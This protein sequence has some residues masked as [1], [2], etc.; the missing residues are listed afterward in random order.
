VRRLLPSAICHLVLLYALILPA[1]AA[2]QTANRPSVYVIVIDGLDGDRVD[3]GGAP[4][5]K[6]MIEGREGAAATY[7][8]E[9]RSTMI[10]E[11]NPNHTSMATGAYGGASGIPGNA[12]AIYGTP[13]SAGACATTGIDESSKPTQSSGE[14]PSCLQAETLF[15]ALDRQAGD[16]VTTAGIFGKPKLGRLF[17]GKRPDGRY[18]ADY[19]WAPCEEPGDD[20]PY[21]KTVP[22]N[23]ATRYAADDSVVMDE[24][25][26]AA[27]E[28]VTADGGTKK[29]DY[30]FVNLPQVDSAGHATGA[31]SVYD[32]AIELADAEIRRFVESQ[33]QLGLWGSRTVLLL[34][35]DHSMD[36]TPEK[37]S[38]DQRF[39]QAGIS[40][41]SYLIVQ[42]GSASLVYLSDRTDPARFDLLKKMRE[43]ALGSGNAAA[44]V[45]G[46]GPISQALYRESNPVDG[47]AANTVDAVHPAWRLSGPRVGDLVVIHEP[48]GAF[49]DPINPLAGNHG[50]PQTRDNFMAL[51][52]P[53][54]MVQQATPPGEA[55]PGYDDTESNP[56]QS[57]N[58]DVAPTV[59]RLLGFGPPRDSQ[60]RILGEGLHAAGLPAA[61]RL[62]VTASPR[63]VRRGRV[64][65]LTFRVMAG[66]AP[67]AGATIRLGNKRATTDA[68]GV[69]R[70]RVRL[71]KTGLRRIVAKRAGYRSGTARIRVLQRR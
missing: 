24:V 3:A 55:K 58:V 65:R 45:T 21:C 69:A 22:I 53:A 46:A 56:R 2:A 62:G 68:G 51:I 29:P 57:E 25:I 28:G 48:G 17:S 60:G 52:G 13:P 15:Q 47:G 42:N 23:P 33:R 18:W 39:R 20:T 59:A 67:V 14:D 10:A 35:S 54:S 6:S 41:D 31:G 40:P 37:T 71:G 44:Q 19:L 12:F 1:T 16:G 32:Q 26:R 8:R 11:T 36:T 70:L 9:S 49:S 43:A 63:R 66:G 61:P 27:R 4:F 64:A 7:W 50:G 34:V 5:I 38:L 30:T